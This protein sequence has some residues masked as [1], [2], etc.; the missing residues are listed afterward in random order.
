MMSRA[1]I[2]ILKNKCANHLANVK[3][4]QERNMKRDV[5]FSLVPR[6]KLHQGKVSLDITKH[7]S[8]KSVLK[9][10]NRVS[11]DMVAAPRL[12]VFKRH[13]DNTLNNMFKLSVSLDVVIVKLSL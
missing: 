3:N 1:H 8:T 13:L 9:H 2:P 11:E 6:F 10:W 7:L 5:L 4:D 12:S